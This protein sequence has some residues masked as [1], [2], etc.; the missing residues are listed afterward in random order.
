MNSTWH[1]SVSLS[2]RIKSFF[3]ATFYILIL[4]AISKIF[5][6]DFLYAG[7][8]FL[9]LLM[10]FVLVI[11]YA[12]QVELKNDCIKTRY[13]V[14]TSQ[15]INLTKVIK[16]TKSAKSVTLYYADGARFTIWLKRLPSFATEMIKE[17]LN[18]RSIPFEQPS[19]IE[20]SSHIK[21]R[22]N[23]EQTAL[24]PEEPVLSEP[25][26]KTSKVVGRKL[27][28]ASILL[29]LLLMM[30]SLLALI[31]NTIY[32]PFEQG[33]IYRAF[34]EGAFYIVWAICSILGSLS[35]CLGFYLIIK[36]SDNT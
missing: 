5:S 27:Q 11:K 12:Y 8:Y 31:S 20:P 19:P 13:G 25:E 36:N 3:K 4:N 29:G 7:N 24:E 21:Q 14:I 22:L 32:L 15:L 9:L 34:N 6:G 2:Y 35:A 10:A 17:Q 26:K 16:F 18:L 30:N 28:N 33:F 1:Y 23:T